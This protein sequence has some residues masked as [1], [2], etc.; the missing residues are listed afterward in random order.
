MMEDGQKLFKNITK[1]TNMTEQTIEIEDI[2]VGLA[3]EICTSWMIYRLENGRVYL[4]HLDDSATVESSGNTLEATIAYFR[5]GTY[6][7]PRYEYCNIN[8]EIY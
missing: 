7:N 1:F 3:F 6:K 2:R 8:P 4:G 5:R